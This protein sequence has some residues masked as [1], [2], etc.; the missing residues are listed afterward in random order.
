MIVIIMF[1]MLPHHFP[2]VLVYMFFFLLYIFP[3]LAYLSTRSPTTD[4]IISIFSKQYTKV[5]FFLIVPWC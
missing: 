3:F 4:T 1:F 5:P 2:T